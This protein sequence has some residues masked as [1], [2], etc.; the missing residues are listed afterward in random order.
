[1]ATALAREELPTCSICYG[2]FINPRYLPGCS[3]IFCENC[4]LTFISNHKSNDKDSCECQC[5][6]CRNQI[7]LPKSKEDLQN[8]VK[9]LEGL[10]TDETMASNTSSEETVNDSLCISCK[11]VD[12]SVPAEKYCFDCQESLCERCSKIRHRTKVL[13]EH[14]IIGLQQAKDAL[15]DDKQGKLIR[16]LAEFSK[17]SKHPD[18]TV[19]VVCKDDD[20][21]C[22]TDCVIET[23]RHCEIIVSLQ[24][25][26]IK[27]ENES[28]VK[29][30]KERVEEIVTKINA[31]VDFRNGNVTEVKQKADMIA[32]KVKEMRAKFN[33]LF[34]ALEESI[35]AKAKAIS[36]NC[37]IEVEEN[38]LKLKEISKT[39]KYYISLIDYAVTLGSESQ[40]VILLKKLAS[41]IEEA[42]NKVLEACQNCGKYEIEL[43]IEPTLQT[44][45]ELCANDTGKLAEVTE[46][47]QKT[48]VPGALEKLLSVGIENIADHNI[49]PQ[50]PP[51]NYN[52]YYG[53]IYTRDARA[54]HHMFLASHYSFCCSVDKNY[55]AMQCFNKEILSGGPYGLT[56]LKSNVIAVSLPKE[57]K[58][59]FFSENEESKHLEV[60]D[61]VNTKFK[62]KA[63]CGLSNGEIAVSWNEPVGFSILS[64][65]CCLSGSRFKEKIYFMKDGAGR[66]LKTFDFMAVD[67]KRSHVI[68]PCTQDKA[69]YCFGYEGKPKFKYSH[70]DL[71]CP[72]G[73]SIS[74]EGNI[75]VCDQTKNAIH[76]VSPYGIRLHVVREGCPEK[77]LAIAFDQSGLQFAVTKTSYFY[78]EGQKVRF[79]R[80]I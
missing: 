5:P 74:G 23:H 46:C 44:L 45:S 13:K 34:D 7:S 41:K 53:M 60:F 77:P 3:H 56:E 79:Y 28:T 6:N 18:K 42:E 14:T 24:K 58:I 52:A 21:L 57:K 17:C 69:V 31:V 25:E 35:C 61:H 40:T 55:K 51:S 49:L 22:C 20:S 76:V 64:F 4:L 59:V 36:K 12:T 8:W 63:L 50:N 62:P 37:A 71:V 19:S 75:F 9:S 1:M 15:K 70:E 38:A 47:Y 65:K 78:K 68:Q 32:G 73:V 27:S 67:E 11:D 54:T 39:L 80:L 43:K 26:D 2:H 30:T 72:R 16:A 48:A 33:T 66:T 29:K 10:I